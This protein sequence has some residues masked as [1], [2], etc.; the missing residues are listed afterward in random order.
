MIQSNWKGRNVCFLGDS[1][2]EGVGGLKAGER[3]FD[4]LGAEFGFNAYGY[5]VNGASFLGLKSQAEKMHAEHGDAVDAIFILAGTNNFY[6]AT[7]LGQWYD[8]TEETVVAQRNNDGTPKIE[9]KRIKR[10]FNFSTET[11]RGA[12]NTVMSYLRHN[13]A[14]KQI[15]LMTPI[16]RAFAA[17]APDN[18]Q[19]NEL[20]SNEIG[21]FI[22][23]YVETVREASSIW[24]TELIDLH[25]ISGLFPLYDESAG[26]FLNFDTDRLHPNQAGNRRMA[27][28]IASKLPGIAL[29]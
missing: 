21:L 22:G 13:Y 17:F 15:V 7:P 16:H 25:R 28:A 11:F 23:D 24:S 2:T 12:I 3:Y 10:S 9:Q 8:E 1:I 20:Y 27:T 26:Y 4:L 14:T 19:Y 5:G 29:Y 18:I 6:G